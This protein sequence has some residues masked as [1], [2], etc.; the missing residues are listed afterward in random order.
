[1]KKNIL[2]NDKSYSFSDYFKL[3]YSTRDIIAEFGYQFKYEQLDL[4]QKIIVNPHFETLKN[5]Y[6]KKLPHISLNSEMA[7][8]EFFISPLL[9]ELL[10]YI[11]VDI[12]VEYMINVSEKLKGTIDYVV[13]S[14]SSFIVIEAKNSELDKGFTQLAVELIAMDNYLENDAHE[15]LYGAVTMGDMWRFGVLDRKNKIISKDIDAFL[16]PSDI[17]KFFAVLLGILEQE[18]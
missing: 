6:Y 4:P 13:R 10:D 7:K 18:N 16:I 5:L 3:A 14:A 17:E 11:D 15:L 9:L 2:D 12:D 1:M 8:R